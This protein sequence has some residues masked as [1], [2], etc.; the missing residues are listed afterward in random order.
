[1]SSRFKTWRKLNNDLDKM[2]EWKTFAEKQKTKFDKIILQKDEEIKKLSSQVKETSDVCLERKSLL[3]AA[4][5][6]I[7]NLTN[8]LVKL[9]NLLNIPESSSARKPSLS[10]ST[11]SQVTPSTLKPVLHKLDPKKQ[12]KGSELRE[13]IN[14]RIAAR[15]FSPPPNSESKKSTSIV[16]AELSPLRRSPRI[17]KPGTSGFQSQTKKSST[18]SSSKRQIESD[19]DDNYNRKTLESPDSSSDEPIIPSKKGKEKAIP[20]KS[21]QTKRGKN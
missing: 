2:S 3:T 9:K 4:K 19:S 18:K 20:K 7:T 8:E 5:T 17:E 13:K 6:D 16:K 15:S 11:S 12:T 10:K 14:K 1:M 21:K